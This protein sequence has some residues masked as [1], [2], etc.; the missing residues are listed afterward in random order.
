MFAR[1]LCFPPLTQLTSF[2]PILKTLLHTHISL[3]T[4]FCLFVLFFFGVFSSFEQ[5]SGFEN[6][7]LVALFVGDCCC[8]CGKFS[9]KTYQHSLAQIHSQLSQ[10]TDRYLNILSLPLHTQI[11]PSQS[12]KILT[13]FRRV[14]LYLPCSAI[15]CGEIK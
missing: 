9:I 5:F 12:K 8:C 2:C 4:I 13:I 6:I 11:L 15:V 14:F 1:L 7:F 3:Y 10:Q